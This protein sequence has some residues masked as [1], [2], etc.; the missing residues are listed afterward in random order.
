MPPKKNARNRR[1]ANEADER[2]DVSTLTDVFRNELLPEPDEGLVA[3]IGKY[4]E[5]N[6]NP[7]SVSLGGVTFDYIRMVRV[8][9]FRLAKAAGYEGDN[10]FLFLM[11]IPQSR[12]AYYLAKISTQLGI[13]RFTTLIRQELMRV[14]RDWDSG[15]F[16]VS[17]E[18]DGTGSPA[19]R[20]GDN[21]QRSEDD[22][23]AG[24]QRELI[25]SIKDMGT[26]LL[27]A[28]Q[29][30]SERMVQTL[31]SV[32]VATT[33]S[34]QYNKDALMFSTNESWFLNGLGDLME[35]ASQLPPYRFEAKHKA[36]FTTFVRDLA[37]EVKLRSE[38]GPQKWHDELRSIFSY[39]RNSRDSS[40]PSPSELSVFILSYA[41]S[42]PCNFV[43]A[44]EIALLM[45]G[46]LEDS[47]QLGLVQICRMNGSLVK[48]D[49]KNA[50][51]K[52]VVVLA[53]WMAKLPQALN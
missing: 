6:G 40:P 24:D 51:T 19:P 34:V 37:Q 47:N 36:F 48:E 27:K 1:Q 20:G 10:V 50:H 43:A 17:M 29:T 49:F 44:A 3:R 8:M 22:Y 42:E 35:V 31:L 28:L 33:A 11:N 16:S 32:P 13:E 4:L 38:L 25:T 15:R 14:A 18:R 7:F 39:V 9:T 41:A 53:G 45:R 30:P 26:N 21:Y 23:V 46:R 52:G 5:E 2:V 12:L